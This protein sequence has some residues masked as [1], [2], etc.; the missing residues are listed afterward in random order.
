MN[1]FFKQ[2]SIYPNRITVYPTE[3][4]ITICSCSRYSSTWKAQTAIT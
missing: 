3:K 2:K 1:V 4:K